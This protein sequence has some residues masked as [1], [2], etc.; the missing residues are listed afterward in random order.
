MRV[1]R[2][3]VRIRSVPN[4]IGVKKMITGR[5]IKGVVAHSDVQMVGGGMGWD[6]L[7]ID[8]GVVEN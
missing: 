1:N 6:G 5:W 3:T 4:V 8:G 7:R 2:A